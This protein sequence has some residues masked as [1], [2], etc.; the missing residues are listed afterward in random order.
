MLANP[1][2]P[3]RVWPFATNE[4]S[5]ALLDVFSFSALLRARTQGQECISA[6]CA[7][8]LHEAELNAPPEE[9]QLRVFEAL[10]ETG[11]GGV[12]RHL[13]STLRSFTVGFAQ[14]GVGQQPLTKPSN[15]S[16]QP[17]LSSAARI[18]PNE[19]RAGF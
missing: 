18:A 10:V 4:S 15:G 11:R 8:R 17:S 12:Q 16:R 2:S 3:D 14:G 13:R 1:T 6:V 9:L 5:R 19:D 7:K